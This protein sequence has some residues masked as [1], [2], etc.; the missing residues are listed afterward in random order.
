MVPDLPFTE[1]DLK[2]AA[3]A[4]SYARGLGYLNQVEDLEIDGTRI[5]ATVFG[6]DAYR[7]RLSFGDAR[8]GVSGDC[9]CPFGVEGNFCKHCVAVGLVA[10]KSGDFQPDRTQVPAAPDHGR[11]SLVSWLSSLTKDELLAELIELA[12]EDPGLRRR[13]ELRAAAAQ[14]DAEAVRNAVMRM[15]WV[16]GFIGYEGALDYADNVSRA[17]DAIGELI[18]AGAAAQAIEVARDAIAWLRQNAGAVDDSSGYVSNAG[19]ELLDV[20][21]RACEA[22]P[23]DPFELADYLADECLKDRCGLTPS[24]VDYMELL[25]DSGTAALHN[26]IAAA[27]KAS[28]DDYHAWHLMESVLEAEGDVDALVALY[29]AHLDERGRQ[30]LR[31]ARKL[32][33][34]GRAEEAL[35]WA[36]RGV[37]AGPRPDTRLIEYLVDRYTAAGR[38]GDVLE[39]RRLLFGADRTLD[40]YRALRDAAAGS[41]VWGAERDTALDLLRKDAATGRPAVWTAWTW[42]GPVLI[43]ALI[44]DGDLGAAWTAAQD[45]ASETQWIRLANAS[46]ADRPTDA[47]A[48]YLKAIERLTQRTGDAVY[49]QIAEHLLAARTCH[50]ALGTTEEFRRYLVLLR[51][52]QKRKRNLMKILDQ[53]GL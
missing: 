24:L 52:A 37:R 47:L 4:T 3:G 22:A 19:Y 25:G 50:E 39:L 20:H 43:D 14:V 18:D 40:N 31:I 7:V 12:D 36:E 28:P 16:S 51:M 17:A 29:A 11:Q 38:A 53:S 44:D 10:L 35:E 46:A 9:S 32:D 23:P 49:R 21:L 26:R 42:G 45:T 41:G 30:Y 8:Y 5:T 6:N 2:R 48:V 15:I 34:V 13:F 27:Y 33:E 1:D